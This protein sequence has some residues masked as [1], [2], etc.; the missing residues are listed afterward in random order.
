MLI[1]L[2]TYSR[3]WHTIKIVICVLMVAALI[4]LAMGLWQRYLCA[5]TPRVT[6]YALAAT[7][8]TVLARLSD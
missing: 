6:G 4:V 3:A 7:V 2:V 8:P 1:E 5:A